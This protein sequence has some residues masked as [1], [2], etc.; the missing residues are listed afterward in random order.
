MAENKKTDA[1]GLSELTFE[2]A[3]AQLEKIVGEMEGG[4]LKLGES[5]ERFE[6]GMKLAKQCGERL[7]KAEKRI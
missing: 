4:E 5:L 2:D 7:G 6:R 1:D 3:L